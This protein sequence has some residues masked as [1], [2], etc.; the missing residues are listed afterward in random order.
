VTWSATTDSSPLLCFSAREHPAV[1]ADF[2]AVR[3]AIERRNGTLH[4][5]AALN[6]APNWGAMA[7]WYGYAGEIAR[8]FFALSN[9]LRLAA[10]DAR[11]GV[12]P[13]SRLARLRLIAGCLVKRVRAH[14]KRQ[15]AHR[16]LATAPP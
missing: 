12:H 3:A 1:K 15:P 5:Y 9:M 13:D 8:A 10:R 14:T 7:A 2:R 4:R 16:A 11:A 6:R